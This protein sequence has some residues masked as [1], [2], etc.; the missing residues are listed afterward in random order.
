MS[1]STDVGQPAGR[2]GE[3]TTNGAVMAAFL[4][5]GIGAF[6]VGF[7]VILSE[8]GI[9]AAPTLYRPAGGVS[10]RT[11]FGVLTW[12]IAWGVL[13]ARWKARSVDPRR[14]FTITLV[15][16]ALGLVLTFPPFW[17]IVGG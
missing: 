6:A 7:W 8:A 3:R 14:V 16:I 9:F 5:A 17:S 1:A 13:H 2:E 15:L 11:T 12:V 10:G 4:A